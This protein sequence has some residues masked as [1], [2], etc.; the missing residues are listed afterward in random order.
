MN[1]TIEIE[2]FRLWN[3]SLKQWNLRREFLTHN[4]EREKPDRLNSLSLCWVNEIFNGNRYGFQVQAIIQEFSAGMR[5]VSVIL[6]EFESKHRPMAR[7]RRISEEQV[8][9]FSVSTEKRLKL[10]PKFQAMVFHK[11]ETKGGNVSENERVNEPE[12]IQPKNEEIPPQAKSETSQ[13]SEKILE[14][15]AKSVKGL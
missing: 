12:Y 2:K 11:G 15:R 7:K 10:P 5:P 14:D 8:E 9:T 3:E 1:K 13:T 4:W 6:D